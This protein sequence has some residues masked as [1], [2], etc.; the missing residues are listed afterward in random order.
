MRSL[1]GDTTDNDLLV[2]GSAKYKGKGKARERPDSDQELDEPFTPPDDADFNF[3]DASAVASY[4]PTNEE[5]EESRRIEEVRLSISLLLRD[6]C[7]VVIAPPLR[8]QLRKTDKSSNTESPQMGTGRAPAAPSSAGVDCC[9]SLV[10]D[11]CWR[12][13]EV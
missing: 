3:D 2:P 1:N 11:Q 12:R 7:I 4:P 6:G 5:E 13:F 9:L 10:F 8:E